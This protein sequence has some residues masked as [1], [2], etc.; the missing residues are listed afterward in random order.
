MLWLISITKLLVEIA[1]LALL[2]QWILG[3]L[4][5]HKR[6][7][8]G[9]YQLL[10]T[11]ASPAMRVADWLSPAWV[12]SQHRPLVAAA[13]LLMAW[14]GLTLIKVVHCVKVGMTQCLS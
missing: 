14:L 5:G 8:N 1:A 6:Q 2:G 7:H 9:V 12:L 11:V 13:L 4:I 3:L 10:Q